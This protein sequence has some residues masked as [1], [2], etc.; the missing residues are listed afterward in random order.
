[1]APESD[2]EWG[3]AAPSAPGG[4]HPHRVGVP[5]GVVLRRALGGEVLADELLAARG[6]EVVA[7]VM[8]G[9]GGGGGGGEDLAAQAVAPVEHAD[10]G[11]EGDGEGLDVLR[12]KLRERGEW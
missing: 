7:A 12:R 2:A 10:L 4:A 9:G 5:T 6:V 11:D 3:T 8:V 1:M